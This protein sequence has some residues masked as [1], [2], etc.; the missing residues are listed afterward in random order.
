[1]RWAPGAAKRTRGP[2]PGTPLLS[3]VGLPV[4]LQSSGAWL[5]EGAGLSTCLECPPATAASRVGTAASP[6]SDPGA[7]STPHGVFTP[8]DSGSHMK[9]PRPLP[10]DFHL[11]QFYDTR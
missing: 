1:M 5:S 4:T 11:G 7:P 2:G 10:G 9:A 8:A 6:H 3:G